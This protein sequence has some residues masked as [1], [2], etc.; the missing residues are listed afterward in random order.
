MLL[1]A[2][3]VIGILSVLEVAFDSGRPLAGGANTGSLSEAR[4]PQ[5]APVP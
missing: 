1:I 5:A 4:P 3:S 2:I